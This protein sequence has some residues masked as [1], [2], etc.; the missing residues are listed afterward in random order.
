MSSWLYSW[1][2]LVTVF[3]CKPCSSPPM[4]KDIGRTYNLL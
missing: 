3:S 1:Y 4:V 2:F